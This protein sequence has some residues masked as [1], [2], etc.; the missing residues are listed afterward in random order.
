MI[1]KLIVHG[2]SRADA[3]DRMRLALAEMRVDGI[4]TNIPLHRALLNLPG[5]IEGGADIHHLERWL[6]GRA[7]A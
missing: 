2:A 3:L 1:A 6:R 5:F 4:A 7:A